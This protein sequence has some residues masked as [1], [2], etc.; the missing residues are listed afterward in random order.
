MFPGRVAETTPDQLAIVMA[1]S[2]ASLTYRQ[3]DEGAN[4]VSQLLASHGLKPGDHVAICLEN[5]PRFFEVVWG[6]HYAGLVYTCC[7]SRLTTD[8]LSYI[9]NDCGAK[10]FITSKYKADQA[11]SV[12]ATTP[13]VIAR[14]MLDGTTSNYDGYE[15]AVAAQSNEPLAERFEGTDM[16]Y[17]SGTTGRPKGVA[18]VYKPEPLGTPPSLLMLAQFVF[19]FDGNTRYLSPAPLYHAA[20][21]R[22]N[23][24]VHRLGGTTVIMEH[25]DAEEYLA[26]IPKYSITHSQVVPT[27]FVR[28]LKLTDAQRR[29]HDVSSLKTVIHAAAPCPV[30]VKR[31]MIEWWGPIIH[32]YYAGTEGNGFVYCNSDQWLAHPGTVGQAISG[33]LHILDEDGNELPAGETGTVF[34][35]SPAVFEYHNDPEKTKSSRDPKGRGW[36]T[37]GDIGYMDADKFLYLTDRKA[38][39][40]ISG[41][42]NIYPQEAENVL[43]NH[44]EVVDVAVFGVPND[45]FGEEVKAVVQPARMPATPE[46][47]AA[48]GKELIAFCRSQLADVKCPR[49]VDFRPDLPRHPTGKLYKRLLKDEYWQNA[50]R[51]I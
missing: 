44:P 6:C 37:L 26:C 18:F 40:I 10:V 22:F 4:R 19:G 25:F 38:F 24:A 23:M 7:S 27:M 14:Y 15:S 49:T 21:L 36:S 45:E 32:E 16:L 48:L 35:E 12:V 5:H 29:A 33:V 17:S 11:E 42:V 46:E 34:F 51:S 30:E 28:M 1:G 20:P 31:K 13:N 50:G 9:I 47:S 3:L 8:E 41:G 43:I 2:G 39:M